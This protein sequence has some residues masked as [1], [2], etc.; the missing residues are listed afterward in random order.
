M[1]RAGQFKWPPAAHPVEAVY[2]DWRIAE[3]KMFTD[4][5]GVL[6]VCVSLGV[7]LLLVHLDFSQ[8]LLTRQVPAGSMLLLFIG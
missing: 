7:E 3:Q 4:V 6:A 5:M 1:A 8:P 2:R